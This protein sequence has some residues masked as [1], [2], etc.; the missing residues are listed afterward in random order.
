MYCL[1]H[2]NNEDISNKPKNVGN[3]RE[4]ILTY[5]QGRR[6]RE[7]GYNE[8]SFKIEKMKVDSQYNVDYKCTQDEY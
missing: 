3:I 5:S 8:I 4:R 7:S 2:N 1:F 6:K